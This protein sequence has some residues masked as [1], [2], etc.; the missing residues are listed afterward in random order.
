M[1]T[2]SPIGC[3]DTQAAT[4]AATLRLIA[5]YEQLS[6]EHLATLDRGMAALVPSDWKAEEVLTVIE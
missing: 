2:A 1:H 5:L 6:P 4:Q 3:G